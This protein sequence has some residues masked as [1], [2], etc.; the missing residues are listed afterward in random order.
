MIGASI[1]RWTMSYFAMAVGW[2]FTAEAMMVAGF[3]FPAAD[4][5]SPDTLVLVHVVSIGWL[6]TAMCGALFQFVPV[7][8]AKPLF[9]EK[10]AL[11]ALGLLTAGLISLVAG[12]LALGGRLPGGLWLL[13][14]GAFLLVAGFGLII[15]D[16]G[17]TAWLRPTGPTRFIL[18]GLA[19]LCATV[20]FGT[21]FA[22]ALVG[23]SGSTCATMLDAG[24]PLH[25]I[26]GVGGW[27]TLTAMGVS[28]RLL[29]MFM[30]SPDLDDRTSGTTLLA[31][32]LATAVA[33]AG[34]IVAVALSSGMNVILS[35]AA[36][37]GLATIA[38]YGRDVIAIFRARRRRQ[39]ELNIR[40]AALSFVSLGGTALLGVM[41]VLTGNFAAHVGAFVYLVVFGWLSGL[42]LAKLY[43]IVAFLT[44]LETYGPVM[45]RS[46]TPRVQDLVAEWRASK[47]F[48]TYYSAVWVGMLMLLADQPSA[49]RATAMAMAIG[50]IG[51]VREVVRTRRLADV[52]D[53][54]RLPGG[55][56]EPHLLFA[57]N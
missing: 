13:P 22:V 56:R 35:I 57:R 39:L 42:V 15:V 40:M 7:L 36:A 27:L 11:P 5:A 54:L 38:L 51:I 23:C 12:F 44:W 20:T 28:Y 46:P 32:A 6:S 16:L 31:G 49:F 55:A 43:K 14:A 24:V 53:P 2:L 4:V 34:G 8:A 26:V 33:V 50:T 41:L 29:S 47:W 10:W 19:S 52:A 9:A 21:A 45:G 3:G 17:L 30:L 37:L 1:S 48:V 18:V 25:A